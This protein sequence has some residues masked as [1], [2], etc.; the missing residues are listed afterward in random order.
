M[1][2][3]FLILVLHCHL[4]YVRHPEH[5]DFLEEDWLFEAVA[6]TY[7]PLLQ[8]LER[9]ERDGVPARLT[10]SFSPTL[11]EM[12]SNSLL[13][14]RCVR[15]LRKRIEL[16]HKEV[17]R[18]RSGPFSAAARMYGQRYQEVLRTYEDHCGLELLRAFGGLAERG[19][20]ELIASAA[21]HALLPLLATE[22]SRRAQV[23]LGLR[24]FQKH[25][26]ARPSGFWLPE[27]AYEPGVDELLADAGLRYFFV[28]THGV[29]LADPRPPL[30]VFAPLATPAGPFAFGRD[31]ETSRQVW[32]ADEGYPGDPDYREFHRDLGFDAELDY[33][34]PYL[35]ANGVRRHL[36][37]K[38]HRVTG[39][40]PLEGKEPY[41]PEAGSARAAEHAAHFVRQRLDQVDRVRRAT[42]IRPG[43]VAPYDAELFGHWW[44][45]GLQFIERVFRLVAQ[46]E[47]LTC[48]TPADYL[49]GVDAVRQEGSPATST[50][51]Y[52]GYFESWVN[53][54]N[55]WMYGPLRSAESRMAR[56]AAQHAS[57]D[58]L[59]RRALDQCAR[60]LLLAQ[61]SDWP[62][63]VSA[64][65]A[66]DYATRR[67]ND[68]IGRFEDLMGQVEADRIDP[69]RLQTCEG[70]DDPFAEM[71][72][73]AFAD[74]S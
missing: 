59:M 67:F 21:T 66:R 44:L 63:L 27:C 9:L 65:A 57:A 16:A 46:H 19:R 12:L 28:D 74:G 35:H 33:V 25:F 31:V 73:R 58:G 39:D 70:L 8:M 72:Y 22:E 7:V 69:R 4:P 29:L 52:G 13:R 6:E 71:D 60:E 49:S 24:S 10:L 3:G 43:I 47:E 51:G 18:T 37:F 68:L 26:G 5:D 40:V 17:E 14:Q 61:S 41:D 20:I 54:S 2:E 55:D 34:R 23:S 45:E 56:A 62:F 32:S 30:G 64:G 1:R 42:G 15:Y 53:G 36:G 11:C 38:Y 50:W 48:L